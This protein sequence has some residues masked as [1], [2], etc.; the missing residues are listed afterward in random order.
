MR[1]LG[2]IKK[3]NPPAVPTFV[4]V[5]LITFIFQITVRPGLNRGNAMYSKIH[6]GLTGTSAL[7]MMAQG[8]RTLSKLLA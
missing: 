7:D 6:C 8:S 1:T 3:M 4:F 2:Q 5:H